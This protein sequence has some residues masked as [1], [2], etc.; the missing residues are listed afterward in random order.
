MQK[1]KQ[2]DIVTTAVALTNAVEVGATALLEISGMNTVTD[3]VGGENVSKVMISRLL[4][5][6]V[7]QKLEAR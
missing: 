3:T 5:D 7:K 6:S 1:Q 2:Q 4:M